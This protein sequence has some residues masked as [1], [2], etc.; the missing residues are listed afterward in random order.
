MGV[1]KLLS[2]LFCIIV[3]GL[4]WSITCGAAS[5]EVNLGDSQFWDKIN[6]YQENNREEAVFGSNDKF[7]YLL[8]NDE[9]TLTKY[10][11]G[12]KKVVIPSEIDGY[13]I[14]E[15]SR[16]FENNTDIV[17]VR[18]SD[19]VRIIGE[20]TFY[21]CTNLKKVKLPKTALSLGE[22][23]FANSGIKEIVLPEGIDTISAYCFYECKEL[24][25]VNAKHI[26]NNEDDYA[27]YIKEFA[28]TGAPMR[29]L[30]TENNI[31]NYYD[32]S[33]DNYGYDCMFRTSSLIYQLRKYDITRWYVDTLVQASS[34]GRVLISIITIFSVFSIV[35]I[36]YLLLKMLL[37][38]FGKNESGNYRRY[39]KLF[40]S[41]ISDINN[42]LCI[43]YYTPVCLLGD[44]IKKVLN[45]I[46]WVV[47]ILFFVFIWI[48]TLYTID[49][50]K[51][52]FKYY[53]PI[54]EVML[55]LATWIIAIFLVL[56]IG[57][58][59]IK[60]INENREAGR[61]HIRVRKIKRKEEKNVK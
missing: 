34:F 23:A 7:E 57:F 43:V 47:G 15:L 46:L 42:S 56:R 54:G 13:P 21:G 11:G 60:K 28:F 4:C 29:V 17:S 39:S 41:G 8:K 9:I 14:V 37:S 18:I 12:K 38:V 31:V 40:E 61:P 59:C 24:K 26:P 10:I 53:F 3:M 48:F 30:K 20:D 35:V 33:F 25:A 50:S 45:I 49:W 27:L 32:V 19:G 55:W 58:Y 22:Y 6:E 2:I 36:V 51:L 44:K 16:T 5:N 52:L 1:K